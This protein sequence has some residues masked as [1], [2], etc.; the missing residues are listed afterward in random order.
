MFVVFVLFRVI[1]QHSLI[2]P[3]RLLT[4]AWTL[5]AN[6]TFLRPGEFLD[7]VGAEAPVTAAAF[8]WLIC[9]TEAYSALE[10]LFDV[11]YLHVV[12]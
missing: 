6:R 8:D 10:L 11:L 4:H 1:E 5:P 7:L 9:N 2:A 3:L 12:Y